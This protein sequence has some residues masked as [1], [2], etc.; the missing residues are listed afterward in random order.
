VSE[1]FVLAQ[2]TSDAEL[3]TTKSKI[4]P[5][6]QISPIAHFAPHGILLGSAFPKPCSVPQSGSDT[7]NADFQFSKNE[8]GTEWQKPTTH[9]NA[10]TS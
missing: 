2:K 4:L 3:A 1:F 10:T 6:V 5:W 8:G 9:R 7:A